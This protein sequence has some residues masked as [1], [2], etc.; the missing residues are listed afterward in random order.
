MKLF[1][2]TLFITFFSLS[3]AQ[4]GIGT[5]TPDASTMLDI[6]SENKGFLGAR[7]ALQSRTDD[8]TILNPDDGLIVYNTNTISGNENTALS[9][10]YYYWLT[11]RW[12]PSKKGE[13]VEVTVN[14][15]LRDY[16]GYI[17][18]GTHSSSNFSSGGI[19]F[20]AFGCKQ[21][22]AGNG[23]WYCAYRGNA[24]FN[25]ETA[26]NA[27]KSRNGYLATFVTL[28][29]W[30]WVKTNLVD[31]TT[32]YNLNNSIWIGYNKV[33]FSGNPTEFNWITGEKSKVNW[34]NNPTTDHAFGSGEPNNSGGNEGC[35]HIV[36][37][38][39]NSNRH[40]NDITCTNFSSSHWSGPY[41]DLIIEFEQ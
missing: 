25:W 27:A 15:K 30:Q 22:T 40:W 2:H 41:T 18:N 26:F 19:N 10:G 7:I 13:V 38:G 23:H 4:I 39:T 14:G 36:S 16:L 6:I 28:A 11:D 1:I 20:T 3:W 24:G 31:N 8:Q 21:W 12:V 32:G 33:N 29:E 17:A 35:V 37:A 9:P 34:S 5:T